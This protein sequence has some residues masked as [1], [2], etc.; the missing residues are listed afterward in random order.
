MIIVVIVS[1]IMHYIVG[2]QRTVLRTTNAGNT[3][4]KDTTQGVEEFKQVRFRDANNGHALCTAKPNTN[5]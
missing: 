5:R 3:W 2:K 4:D 1:L